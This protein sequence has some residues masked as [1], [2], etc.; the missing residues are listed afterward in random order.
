MLSL[1]TN[2]AFALGPRKENGKSCPIMPILII[3]ENSSR[4]SK[5]P[6]HVPVT[7]IMWLMLFKEIIVV[8]SE[9]LMKPVNTLCGQTAQLFIVIEGGRYSY[10]WALMGYIWLR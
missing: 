1:D 5:K 6:Q 3:F 9:N 10:H 8:Y 4:S 2:S 7:K